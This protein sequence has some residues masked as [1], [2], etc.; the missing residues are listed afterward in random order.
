MKKQCE[1]DQKAYELAKG[2]LPGL[3]VCGV[4]AELVERY[5]N[6]LS[7]EP[8]PVTK[9]QLYHRIL[10]SAQNTGMKSGVIGKA[11]GGVDKLSPVLCKFDAQAVLLRY[12]NDWEAVLDQIVTQVKPRGQIRRIRR[13]TPG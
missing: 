1:I 11:I 10:K 7:L 6:P 13:I 9:N 5:L 8:K 2:Y 3:G 12:D 4:T